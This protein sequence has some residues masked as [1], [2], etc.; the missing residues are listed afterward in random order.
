MFWRVD[1]TDNSGFHPSEARGGSGGVGE[2]SPS[3]LRGCRLASPKPDAFLVV[4]HTKSA[5]GFNFCTGYSRSIF[6][7]ML[8]RGSC[9][10]T[11]NGYLFSGLD[12]F[13]QDVIEDGLLRLGEPG[14][15]VQAV[16]VLHEVRLENKNG[17]KHAT[18]AANYH[19][20]GHHA[21]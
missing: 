17:I 5:W 4:L 10:A 11:C 6:S 15:L 14:S 8:H 13:E 19:R 7:S 9:I 12:F 18:E 2:G 21:E 20:S 16:A 3:S 1:T